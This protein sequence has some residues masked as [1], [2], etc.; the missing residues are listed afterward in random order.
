MSCNVGGPGGGGRFG[1]GRGGPSMPPPMTGGRGSL[2]DGGRG[3]Y[4]GS[5]RGGGFGGRGPGESSRLLLHANQRSL[6][7]SL[8]C[9]QVGQRA[10]WTESAKM[11]QNIRFANQAIMFALSCLLPIGWAKYG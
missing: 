11:E 7:Y 3:T 4:G 2:G 5:S 9:I 8:Q 6:L 10:C 1:A